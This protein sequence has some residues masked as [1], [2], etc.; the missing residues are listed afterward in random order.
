[1]HNSLTSSLAG[2]TLL[3]T[4]L[5]HAHCDSPIKCQSSGREILAKYPPSGSRPSGRE[6]ERERRRRERMRRE[7]GRK[8]KGRE[9][10]EGRRGEWQGR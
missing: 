6:R 9:E 7:G 5:S 3:V 10:R 1:M 4:V 8:R 2:V